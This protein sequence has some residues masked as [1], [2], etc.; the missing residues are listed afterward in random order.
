[1]KTKWKIVTVVGILAVTC[2]A[3]TWGIPAAVN[4]KAHKQFIEQKIFEKS[5]YLVNIGNSE[6]SMGTFPSVWLKSDNIAILNKDGSKALSIVNPKLKIK[7]FP[8]IFKKIEIAKISSTQLDANFIL[9]KDSKFLL[10]EYPITLNTNKE[11]S[12]YTLSKLDWDLGGYNINLDD[13]KNNQQV[14]LL[15]E[16]LEHGNYVRNKHVNLSTQGKFVVNNKPTAYMAD[17]SVNLPINRFSEDKL[18]I[19]ANLQ[20]F[21]LASI[22]DYVNI[23]SEGRIKKLGGIITFNAKTTPDKFGHKK[24]YTKLT[25]ERLEIIGKDKA[26]SVIYPEKLTAKINFN[27]IEN[28]INFTNSTLEADKIHAYLDGKVFNLGEKVPHLNITAEVKNTRLE[29]VVGILPW[30]EKIL[31]DFNLYKL[32][33]YVFFGDGEGKVTFQGQGNRPQVN[34]KVKLSNTYLIHPIKG[35]PANADVSLTFR[36]QKMDLDVYVPTSKGQY[37]TVKGKVKIDGSKYSELEIK[38]TDSVILTPVEEVLTPLH[39]ILKFQLGPVPM[40]KIAGYGNIDMRSAGKKVDPHIWGNINFKNGTASFNDVHNLVLHNASGNVNFNDTKVTFKTTSGT[41][42]GRPVEIKGDCVVLGKMNVYVT[43][44][45]QNIPALIK[46]INT[47]PILVDVQKAIAP[48]TKPTGI[49]DVFLHIYGEVKNAEEVVF[50]EDLFSKGTITLHNATTVLQDTFLPFTKVNGVVNFDQYNS[51][52]D[53]NGYV[54]NSKIH[55][56]GT[57]TLNEIDLVAKSDKFAIDDC[58]DLLYPDVEMPFK[59]EIGRLYASFTGYYKGKADAGQLD[60][61]KVKVDGKFLPNMSSKEAIRL[62]GG[63]FTIRKGIL[64]T[65]NLKGLFNN[66]PFTLTLTMSDIYDTMAISDAVF[67]FKNFDINTVNSIKHQVKLPAQYASQIDNITDLKGIIDIKGHIKNGNVHADTNLKDTSFV[68]KPLGAVIRVL[69]GDANMRGNTLY[70]NRVNSR[71][72]SMPVFMNGSISDIYDNPNLN[73]FVSAKPTQAFFDRFLNAKSVYP[74]K[75]KG[76]IN[77]NANLKGRLDRMSSKSTLNIGENS[78]IYYMGATLAGAPTGSMTAGELT[79]NPVSVISDT[80]LYPNK[81]QINSLKYNQTVTSQNR[82]KSVQN[83]LTASGEV[84]L[85][86]DNVLGFKNLKIKTNQPTDAKIFNVLLKKPT[87]KQGVFSSDLT[88]NGTSL[89]PYIL[90]DLNISSIDIPLLDATI[91]DIKIGFKNDYINVLSKAVVLTNDI[92]MN[93]KIVNKPQQP[94]IIEDLNIQMEA[95]NLN[96]I[97]DALN[98]FEA[99][100]T[101]NKHQQTLTTVPISAEQLIIKNAQ[102]NAD[103]I[104]IKKAEATNFKSQMTLGSDN[105]FRINNYSFNLANGTVDG[106]I[107]YNLKTFDGDAKMSINNADAQI[108]SENFFDLPGQMY[109]HVTGDM[110]VACHGISSVECINTLTGEGSFEVIDGRMPKLGSLEYLL[111]AGNLITGGITGLSINGIIDLITPLKTGNFEKISGNIKVKD[112]IANDI[113]VYSK[114]K[115]L[116]M[117]LTGNYNISTLVADMEIYGSLSK[118]FSTLLGKIGNSSLNRLFNTIPGININEINPTST[119]KINKIPNFDKNNV[120]RVFKAEIFGDI[121]GSNYVKSFRWIKN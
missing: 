74:V 67:N 19:A 1:M 83:Q 2:G 61:D 65:S 119:S 104:L 53:V 98:D 113:N 5:G 55:V 73:L 121:N 96:V 118:N 68:Y 70:L 47:S 8:L 33:K 28:G 35:A 9:T 27:T 91:R 52:Y 80:V 75:I 41:I 26:S 107:N 66:N 100:S 10:G 39:E 31:P 42:N 112:G 120:L 86:K 34:G 94:A 14:Q 16:Y 3:Y 82:T 12:K 106:N 60:Y 30:S 24:V 4:I 102:V 71:V 63:T 95:L 7:L 58:N 37:V 115:D 44:K 116:N 54:R 22:S 89:A 72:S 77:F 97:S 92:I 84:S 46:T 103:K 111:K 17:I 59:K 40:M 32:K 20:N 105:I 21:D 99:D 56:K 29:N 101:R 93:A 13:K 51:D 62:N 23:L 36:G 79:T 85:M 87:I 6:L 78:S 49:A 64:K 50:N 76:D 81:V 108:I 11:K 15:G 43:S 25:T 48:F 109:G 90:G 18:K 110:N 88:I 117:Y 69:N 38:S 114:G 45:G 57:G